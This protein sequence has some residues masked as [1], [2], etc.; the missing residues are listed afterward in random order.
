MFGELFARAV[1]GNK[2]ALLQPDIKQAQTGTSH[3]LQ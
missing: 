2:E 1:V 3:H